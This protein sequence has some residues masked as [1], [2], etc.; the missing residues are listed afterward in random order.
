[1]RFRE[2]SVEQTR[3]R[4]NTDGD[5]G[6][7]DPLTDTRTQAERLLALGDQAIQRVLSGN[8]ESFLNASRQ[9]GGE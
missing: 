9:Q 1:M 5:S 7:G 8:S 4:V 6:A 3:N 2:R